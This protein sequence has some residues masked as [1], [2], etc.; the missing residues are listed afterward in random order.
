MGLKDEA[1]RHLSDI[2]SGHPESP[3]A[4]KALFSLATLKLQQQNY[5]SAGE[6]LDDLM[7]RYPG[8]SY[9]SKA[10]EIRKRLESVGSGR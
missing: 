7:Q 5:A 1:E 4:E 8:G 3:F 10:Y 6:L 2:V 9:Y